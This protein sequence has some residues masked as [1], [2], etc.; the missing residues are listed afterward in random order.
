ME[1]T[2]FD[3]LKVAL[4]RDTG[5]KNLE[6][7]IYLQDNGKAV[8]T[9]VGVDVNPEGGTNPISNVK[10]EKV[11]VLPDASGEIIKPVMDAVFNF[12]FQ[13]AANLAALRELMIVS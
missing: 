11:T 6:S 9:L 5:L 1:F 3:N 10:T 13:G 4:S 8:I 7:L 2:L 12:R